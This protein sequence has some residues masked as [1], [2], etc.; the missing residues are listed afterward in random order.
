MSTL[1]FQLPHNF[2][3]DGNQSLAERFGLIIQFLL[4]V[5]VLEKKLKLIVN[6]EDN[7]KLR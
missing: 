3:V 6:N 1:Q 5:G 2:K 7:H 4:F